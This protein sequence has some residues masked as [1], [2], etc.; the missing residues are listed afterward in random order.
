MDLSVQLNKS[1]STFDKQRY[2]LARPVEQVIQQRAAAVCQFGERDLEWLQWQEPM[3]R[4]L[5]VEVTVLD[6]LVPAKLH[7][8]RRLWSLDISISAHDYE[9]LTPGPEVTLRFMHTLEQVL[10]AIAAKVEEPPPTHLGR[11]KRELE[12]LDQGGTD[13]GT[14]TATPVR[15]RKPP[16]PMPEQRFWTM[17]ARTTDDR[18]GAFRLGWE[19]ADR[20][21]AR[22][23]LLTSTLDSPAHREAAERVMGFVSEDVWDDVGAWVVS[24]G[25]DVYG[26]ALA[27]PAAISAALTSLDSEDELARGEQLL[28]LQGDD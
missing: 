19:Q 17:I 25:Q 11:S 2:A 24:Q 13:P 6:K 26:R 27:D 23:R 22:M 9:H 7:P 21:T 14:G 4:R 15:V 18:S 5:S 3:N 16:A 20:F 1:S 12:W 10:V 28:Y 8:D